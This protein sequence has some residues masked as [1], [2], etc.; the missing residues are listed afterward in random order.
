MKTEITDKLIEIE[1]ENDVV[2]LY[3]CESGSRAW[4]FDNA[5]SDYDVR[6]IYKMNNLHEYLTLSDT[7]DV[8]E[9]MDEN[10]DIV[11]WDIKKALKLHYSSNPN[12]REWLISPIKYIDWNDNI[13]RGLE[14]FDRAKLKYHY[15]SI[16]ANN[17]K[18]LSRDDLDLTKRTFKM[19]L[20][21]CRCILTWMVI[22]QDDDPSINIFDLL[23]QVKNLDNNINQ[24]INSLISFYKSNCEENLN[25]QVIDNI[26]QW[27]G[28][29]LAIMRRDFPK[30][31]KSRDFE[32]YNQRFFDIVMPDYDDFC[33]FTNN[34]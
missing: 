20:Y 17:W 33:N 24:D 34:E 18:M 4:G 1:N 15:T 26:K 32:K 30:T 12:L 13:F 22:N 2:I 8:I 7:S 3:A 6:F 11:G 5:E 21:N 31:E 27:M 25:L 19:L 29:N 28:F 23:N 16:A 10:L 9:Y 14:E